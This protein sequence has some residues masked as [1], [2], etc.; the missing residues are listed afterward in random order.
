MKCAVVIPAAGIGRRFGSDLPKQYLELRGRSIIEH[1]IERFVATPEVT[2]ILIAVEASQE[3]RLEARIAERGWKNV[4]TIVGGSTRQ[5]SVLNGVVGVAGEVAYIAV[6][7]AVRPVFARET[8][9]RL[10]ETVRTAAG[11]VPVLRPRDTIHRVQGERIMSTM[12]RNDLAA[13]QTP[14]IF[15]SDVLLPALERAAREGR[16]H[17]DEAGLVAGY[18]HEVRVIEGDVWNLKI[19]TP[20]DLAMMEAN[21]GQWS[22]L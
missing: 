17:T 8:F 4:E 5:H 21:F 7:D 10:L 18:G 20:E 15:R 9:T 6:H 1:A 16:V 11:A 3:A 12:N 19:T 2:R 14:Q 22:L 13:A